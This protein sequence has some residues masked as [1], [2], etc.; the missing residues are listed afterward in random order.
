MVVNGSPALVLLILLSF[1]VN[2]IPVGVHEDSTKTSNSE[3]SPVVEQLESELD[4]VA[5]TKD[6]SKKSRHSIFTG[7]SHNSE[8]ENG[9]V[10]R[11]LTPAETSSLVT[12]SVLKG[13]DGNFSRAV[14][15]GALESDRNDRDEMR[16]RSQ[17]KN[18]N[19]AS[20]SSRVVPQ[21]ALKYP[22]VSKNEDERLSHDVSATKT[23]KIIVPT[24]SEV[25]K[26]PLRQAA[27]QDGNVTNAN[28]II[29]DSPKILQELI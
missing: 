19:S 3:T 1:K 20:G 13:V 26:M 11:R 8:Y 25:H 17:Q 23:S 2:G 10:S 15:D 28:L 16:L 9:G 4:Q 29:S 18:D 21:D 14:D 27:S 6:L 12:Y 5:T 24:I 7:F 22:M